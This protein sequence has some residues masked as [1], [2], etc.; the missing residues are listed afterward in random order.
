MEMM[1]GSWRILRRYTELDMSKG[2]NEYAASAAQNAVNKF[3]GA[4]GSLNRDNTPVR[5]ATDGITL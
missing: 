2:M 4:D 1:W 5:N 3:M